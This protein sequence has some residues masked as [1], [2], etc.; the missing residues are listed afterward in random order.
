MDEHQPVVEGQFMAIDWKLRIVA[1][2]MLI[3][4]GSFSADRTLIGDS[5]LVCADGKSYNDSWFSID[6]SWR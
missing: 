4:P 5:K 1:G 2:K 6:D 3:I